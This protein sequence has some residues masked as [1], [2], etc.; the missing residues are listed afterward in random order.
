M[1]SFIK[2]LSLVVVAGPLM[3]ARTGL[4]P[5]GQKYLAE[6]KKRITA[7][8]NTIET[9]R[10][11]PVKADEAKENLLASKR[12]LDNVQ[13]EQ[14]K[15][16]EAAALQKKADELLAKLTPVL[17]RTAIEERNANIQ[18]LIATIEKELAAPS[19]DAGAD[20]RLRDHF[21]M[22]RQMVREVLEKEPANSKALAARDRENALWQQYREQREARKGGPR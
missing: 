14:P 22:L 4:T 19:R 13:V 20:E 3:V 8:E 11:D 1:T 12:F 16:A 7:I 5:D 18:E 6:A 15:N 9:T 2:L 17:L 21:D 10:T